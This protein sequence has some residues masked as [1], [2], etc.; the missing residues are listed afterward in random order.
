MDKGQEYLYNALLKRTKITDD[1][2]IDTWATIGFIFNGL[3]L[4]TK[5]K[6]EISIFYGVSSQIFKISTNIT[7]SPTMMDYDSI[8]LMET[9]KNKVL[10]AELKLIREKIEKTLN[11]SKILGKVYNYRTNRVEYELENGHFIEI[12]GDNLIA[13]SIELDDSVFP[14]CFLSGRGRIASMRNNRIN[15]IL[16]G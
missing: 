16:N 10:I 15:D 1:Y 14:D 11:R 2:P 3:N 6:V 12:D 5:F 8:Y 9:N 7:Y 4:S 13:P